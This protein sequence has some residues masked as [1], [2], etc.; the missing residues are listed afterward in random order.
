M[1]DVE[2]VEG[3]G[4]QLTQAAKQVAELIGHVQEE[5]LGADEFGRLS[6][7]CLRLASQHARVEL[8]YFDNGHPMRIATEGGAYKTFFVRFLLPVWFQFET[9]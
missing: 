4:Q 5:T 1:K 7:A 6:E 3:R 2:R 8:S 9:I